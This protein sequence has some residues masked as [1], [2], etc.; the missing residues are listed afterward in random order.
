LELENVILTQELVV[1]LT[2]GSA[3]SSLHVDWVFVPK[4]VDTFGTP[5]AT[6]WPAGTLVNTPCTTNINLG[7]ACGCR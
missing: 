1:S 3:V 5:S 2:A 6:T 7:T 4:G